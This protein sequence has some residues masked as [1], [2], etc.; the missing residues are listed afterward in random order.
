M[1]SGGDS[2]NRPPFHSTTAVD[3]KPSLLRPLDRRLTPSRE[4]RRVHPYRTRAIMDGADEVRLL[5]PLV[6]FP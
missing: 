6:V 2:W 5:I 4:G 3:H 1:V